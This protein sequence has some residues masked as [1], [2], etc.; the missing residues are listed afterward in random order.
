MYSVP[1]RIRTLCIP[2]HALILHVPT[3]QDDDEDLSFFT[4]QTKKKGKGA[5][6]SARA[7]SGSA[8]LPAASG[9][10]THTIEMLQTFMV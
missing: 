10:M 2:R 3:H 8:G 5:K 9:K 6:A 7:A 1:P 4:S